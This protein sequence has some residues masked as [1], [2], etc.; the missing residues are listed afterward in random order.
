MGILEQITQMRGRGM[1]DQEIAAR[2]QQQGVS[3][4]EINDAFSQAEIKSAVTNTGAMYGMQTSIMD[5]PPV[6]GGG[7]VP[8]TQ[9][10]S[11]EE[12]AYAPQ[13]SA[14]APQTEYMAQP[15]QEVYQEAGY[16]PAGGADTSTMIEISE[17]VF[18]EKIKKIEKSLADLIEFKTL[19]HSKIENISERLKRIETTIDK[20]QIAILEKVGSYG[21]DLEATKKEIAMVRD[22]FEKI[23]NPLA[24]MGEKKQA[25]KQTGSQKKSFKEK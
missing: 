10:A 20:L 1:P 19:S 5:E 12:Y 24:E 23:V 16:A 15:G 4:R 25:P 21:K 17:Q 13:P 8:Q 9:E 7:Y 18:S 14:Q 3:P 22:S 2:L 6:S 11:E